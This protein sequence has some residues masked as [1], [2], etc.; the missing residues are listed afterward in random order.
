MIRGS[1]FY[2]FWNEKENTWSTSEQDL[3]KAVDAELDAFAEKNKDRFADSRVHILHMWD[4]E[5]GS[6]DIWHRYCQKQMRD[7][8][9]PLDNELVFSN[10][11]TTKEDYS[12]HKLPY[13]LESGSTEAYD[14]LVSELYTDE[15]R[16]KFEWAIG[17][18]VTGASKRRKSLLYSMVHLELVNQLF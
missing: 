1:D 5:S 4:A 6:I 13:P 11:K 14:E 9:K 2:A 15:Q 18:I 8:F 7:N 16:H 17:A 3:V 10:Q 12:S